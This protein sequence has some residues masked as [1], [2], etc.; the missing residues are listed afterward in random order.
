M[1]GEGVGRLSS[2]S[3]GDLGLDLPTAR[4]QARLRLEALQQDEDPDLLPVP[5]L[6]DHI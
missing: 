1:L 3:A 4:N 2:A 6:R 5:E